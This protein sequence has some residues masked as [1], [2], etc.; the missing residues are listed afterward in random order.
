MFDVRSRM[1]SSPRHGFGETLG[2][3]G[4]RSGSFFML[5]WARPLDRPRHVRRS[6]LHRAAPRIWLLAAFHALRSRG[7]GLSTYDIQGERLDALRETS[8]DFYAAL[9]SAYLM[10]RDARIESLRGAG[11]CGFGRKDARDADAD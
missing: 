11:R 4:V 1:A 2:R 5:P 7:N 8:V 3:Y 10:D 9:R 6:R